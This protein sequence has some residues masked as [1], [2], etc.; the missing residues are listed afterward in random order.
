M[1]ET[2]MNTFNLHEHISKEDINKIYENVSSKILNYFEEIVKKINTEIQNRNVSH[3]LEEFMKELD[4]IR[5]ISSIA[6]KTTEIYYATVEKLVG[7]V[8]E[9]R[10]D[11][12]ELLRVMFRREGKVDYNKLTQCLSNLKS[13]HWIEIYRTGVYSDVINNVEQQIIQYIIELKEPIMQVNLDLDKIEYVNKIVSEINEMKHFQNFI[14]SVDKHINEVNSFLQE[15]TNNVF[16]SSKAD[17]ALRYLEICKQIHVL[18][19]NDCLSVLNSLEEF[20]RNFSNIIQNE[21]ESSF[22]MIKQYQ[23]QNKE[24]GEKFTDIYRTYRNII[25]EKISGVS[26]QIIDA[27]K[28]FDYQRVA[29]KMMALQS[30]NE[31][32]KHYYAEVKQSLNASLNLLIDGTKAQAIT[33][34]NNIEIEEIKLIG[35]NLKRIERARQFIEK[36]LDAPDEIDNCIEDVKEKIEKR[37]KRFLVGVKTLI[38]NHNFFEAD[39]KIDSITLVC[40]LLGKYCGKEISYQIEEL[41]ES[42]KDIVST[43][44]VDKY[45]EMNINQYT[46]NPLTDIFAR[47]E[48]VNNTNPVYNEALSTIK[49]KILT[50]FREELDK[51]KSKQP[52]DSENIHIRRFESAV[53]YLPEAMRSALEVELKYCKDDI[54]LRIR[55]NE[56]KL[57]NAFSSRDVKS[58]KNV[59]LEYQSSQ[60]MQSF[61][62]KGE[63]LALRQIQEIILKINQ[64]FEN[65]E[66]REALTN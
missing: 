27:I 25:F 24:K 10:R 36:H 51:A 56:K 59:L 32:G 33:L 26:Q 63:E 11:A 65:Y 16:Y 50:K 31:V 48:Q 45:A 6:L 23:N 13:T 46:L 28:E 62:N 54:V 37:I 22:E 14:P 39:K 57:Q 2:A 61:I 20:I 34:G 30:S 40:T 35:E 64:N 49:E 52:P 19:R 4:S 12:E 66:I 18:I 21:M 53:K 3:T 42:Q 8:Y 29:D 58:M 55:D 9:S 41:R 5:T 60:G 1:L 15:I 38:D 47:F 43:N 7:Y 17:K 44:V